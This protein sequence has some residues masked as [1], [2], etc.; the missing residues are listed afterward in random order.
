MGVGVKSEED[1]LG[2]LGGSEK[3]EKGMRGIVGDD[4][5]GA[6]A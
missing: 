1:G 4:R 3:D 6:R 2:C 5:G